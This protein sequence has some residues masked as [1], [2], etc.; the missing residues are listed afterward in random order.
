MLLLCLLIFNFIL[1]TF[2][3][4]TTRGREA[5]RVLISYNGIA[6]LSHLVLS[7]R[8]F[9]SIKGSVLIPVTQRQSEDLA[10]GES[11]AGHWLVW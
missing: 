10:G 8:F 7:R 3:L 4:T 1:V 6:P 11:S 2:S 5:T 9:L